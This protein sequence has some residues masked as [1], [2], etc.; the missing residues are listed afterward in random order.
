MWLCGVDMPLMLS[1][2]LRVLRGRGAH[3]CALCSPFSPSLCRELVGRCMLLCFS[4]LAAARSCPFP[5]GQDVIDEDWEEWDASKGKFWHHMLAGSCAGV[6][7]HTAMFP[8]DTYKVCACP[9]RGW[10][11]ARVLRPLPRSPLRSFPWTPP[12]TGHPLR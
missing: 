5:P 8:F 10:G 1:V 9:S 2:Y 4:F 7:E 12:S 6:M 11:R 3:G